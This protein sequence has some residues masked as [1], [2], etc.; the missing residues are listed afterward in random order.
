[1]WDFY[2]DRSPS[3]DTACQFVGRVLTL[4]RSKSEVTIFL[5]KKQGCEA[6]ELL[7]KGN[8]FS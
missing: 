8:Q 6:R 1:M 5:V 3:W 7:I 2:L 4:A